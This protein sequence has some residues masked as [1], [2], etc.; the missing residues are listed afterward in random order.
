MSIDLRTLVH[1]YSCG[2]FPMADSR[3][4][5][6]V[7]WLQPE[8]RAILPLDR[9]HLS[10][11][12]R[13]VIASDRFIV[14]ADQDFPG[15]IAQCAA[16]NANRPDTWINNEIETAFLRL[17]TAGLAHSVECWVE[18]EAGPELVGGLYGLALGRVFFGESMFSRRT[19]ASK[20]ALAWLVA[21]LRVAGFTL[22]DC[23]FMTDHLASLGAIE[24]DFADYS[25]LL[26]E[27]VGKVPL[28][29]PLSAAA[30]FGA[31]DELVA[32][33]FLGE[34]T[35]TVSSPVSGQLIVQLLTQTS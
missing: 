11:S 8:A 15:V 13:K 4:A 26:D 1:A 3:N 7:F 21:R 28:D 25:A 16:E 29:D 6:D 30:A 35:R 27:A 33:D 23:Q 24:L 2:L 12:L 17:H 9:F 18:S 22:L 14:T 5:P 34:A 31:L 20:T 10:R 19:D 32:P